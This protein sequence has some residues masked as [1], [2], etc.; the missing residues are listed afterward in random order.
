M[1]VCIIYAFLVMYAPRVCTCGNACGVVCVYTWGCVRVH[2]D[3]C[4][5]LWTRIHVGVH[6]RVAG[7]GTFA[8]RA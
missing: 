1:C 6:E 2:V 5:C 4:M 7:K 3:M 8:G